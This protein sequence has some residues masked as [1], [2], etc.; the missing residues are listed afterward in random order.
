MAVDT[1]LIRKA[2]T[3]DSIAFNELVQR[4]DRIVFAL[5]ARYV[6]SADEAKDIFQ[7]VM[8]RVFRGLPAFRFESEFSTWLHRIT[9]NVCL[10]H[11]KATRS[12]AYTPLNASDDGETGADRDLQATTRSPDDAAIDSDTARHIQTALQSLSPRQR[13]V[14][15]LRHYEGQS[16]KEI[17][18]TLQCTEGTVKRYLFTATRRMREQLHELL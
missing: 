6:N 18:G 14:F 4:H 13:M 15:T 1:D 8:I 5:A 10:S 12:S 11:R 16:L 9:V 17:A 2:Q 7:E 3:G